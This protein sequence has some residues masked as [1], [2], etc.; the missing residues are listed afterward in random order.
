MNDNKK[1]TVSLYIKKDMKKTHNLIITILLA[2]SL[3]ITMTACHYD[4]PKSGRPMITVTVE[5]LRYFTEQIAGDKFDVVTLVPKGGSPE[6]YE[7][8]PQ[9]MVDL[10]NSELLIKVG[11]L[12]FEQTWM[13]RLQDN[14][15]HLIVI[16]SS[17][18]IQRINGDNNAMPDPHTWMSTTNALVIAENIYRALR[19]VDVKDSLYFKERLSALRKTILDTGVEIGAKLDSLPCKTF[20]IYHPSLTYFAND[21]GLTQLAIEEDGHEPSTMALRSLVRRAKEEGVKVMLV[22]RE[23]MNRD[24]MMVEK[25]TGAKAVVI[26]PLNYNWREEM[27]GIADKLSK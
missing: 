13:R 3:S 7:P 23:Y 25:E 6:T 16:D 9:Q 4:K 15:H 12:G 5:P 24:V 11:N 8:T 2:A 14:S 27:T 22:Q 21:Y 10:A 19:L 20:L 17:E 1:E 18:D 26:N